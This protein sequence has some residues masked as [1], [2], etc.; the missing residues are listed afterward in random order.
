[1]QHKKV[2]FYEMYDKAP[3]NIKKFNEVNKVNKKVKKSH[4]NTHESPAPSSIKQN[5][6]Y[7]VSVHCQKKFCAP[8][9]LKVQKINKYCA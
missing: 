9:C 6:L 8:F 1:M 7:Q 4:K 5:I 2:I 3:S